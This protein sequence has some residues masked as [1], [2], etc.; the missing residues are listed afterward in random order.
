MAIIGISIIGFHIFSN[1]SGLSTNT[2]TDIT[3]STKA[4]NG[5]ERRDARQIDETIPQFNEIVF[6]TR[7][8]SIP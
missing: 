2:S 7:N 3:R 5:V 8:P 1:K 4:W 6:D